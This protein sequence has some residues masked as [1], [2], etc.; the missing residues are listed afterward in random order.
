MFPAET[1]SA[2]TNCL[3][4]D[5]R[6]RRRYGRGCNCL[7][8]RHEIA[9]GTATS[10]Q[11]RDVMTGVVKP[12]PMWTVR[13]PIAE[14][15]LVAPS[16]ATSVP[17]S[18]AAKKQCSI[19]GESRRVNHPSAVGPC[20]A[21]LQSRPNNKLLTSSRVP[22]HTQVRPR[23][24]LADKTTS[25]EQNPYGFVLGCLMLELLVV[26]PI[27]KPGHLKIPSSLLPQ[28]QFIYPTACSRRL[29]HA[30]RAGHV[31]S[32][33]ARRVECD[34]TVWMKSTYN[35]HMRSVWRV[36]PHASIVHAYTM[37]SLPTV[38]P[39]PLSVPATALMRHATIP[40]VDG[41]RTSRGT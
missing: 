17:I 26:V 5:S 27:E 10:R 6:G 30:V 40:P 13:I 28:Q 7:S 14:C 19:G 25:P 24:L 41:T 35:G 21:G 34:T 18:I 23:P 11:P 20:H 1:A 37:P 16:S 31:D 12:G 36:Q 32:S 9:T 39:P 33:F 22:R 15:A 3:R 2:A 8:E 4:S 29:H 38:R